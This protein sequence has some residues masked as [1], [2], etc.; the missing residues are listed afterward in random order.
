[1]VVKAYAYTIV[2]PR[3]MARVGTNVEASEG[4]V[5]LKPLLTGICPSDTAYFTGAR[6]PD[7]LKRAYPLIPFHECVAEDTSGRV[8]IPV[9]NIPCYVR[10]KNRSRDS[11]HACRTDGAGEN[12]C[13]DALFSSSNAPGFARTLFAHPKECVLP[14]HKNV[15]L[16]VACL[17]EPL[18][19]AVHATRDAGLEK[20]QSVCVVGDGPIGRA[21]ALL[22]YARGIRKEDNYIVGVSESRL[23]RASDYATT[24]NASHDSIE[25]EF[26]TVFECVGGDSH[27]AVLQRA[28]GLVRPGGKLVLL[29]QGEA[30]HTS[31][32]AL[33]KKGVTIL[34]RVRSS[35]QDVAEALW[36]MTGK[37]FGRHAAQLVGDSV[38]VR[39]VYSFEKAFDV[40]TY[41]VGKQMMDWRKLE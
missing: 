41:S 18:S 20:G 19:V 3:K 22:A 13:P 30:L 7:V 6:P 5:L 35:T 4:D 31:S 17:A 23:K 8:V 15:P 11:C 25:R 37:E 33:M 36:R 28:L 38:H 32:R 24:M 34:P 21:N 1:M 40:S 16:E 14:V 27:S 26:D 12:Y 39:D 2:S 9:P 10:D 29:G